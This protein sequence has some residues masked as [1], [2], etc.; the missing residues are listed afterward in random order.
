MLFL[1]LPALLVLLLILF[2][3]LVLQSFWL[4]PIGTATQAFYLPLMGLGRFLG[5]IIPLSFHANAIFA[6]VCLL[7]VSFAGRLVGEQI[8]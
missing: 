8:Y 2:Q 4:N 7:A 1:N 6:F 3:T 5:F